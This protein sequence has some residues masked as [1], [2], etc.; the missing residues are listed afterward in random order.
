MRVRIRGKGTRQDIGKA[1]AKYADNI[2]IPV[3][4]TV[5]KQIGRLM[6][7]LPESKTTWQDMKKAQRLKKANDLE[8]FKA[9]AA[10]IKAR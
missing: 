3:L 9:L 10:E 7:A 5:T 1:V 2:P 8:G 4:G 6:A